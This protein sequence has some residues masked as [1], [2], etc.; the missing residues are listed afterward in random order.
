MGQG[1]LI[2]RNY[3]I[4]QYKEIIKY[5]N[6]HRKGKMDQRIRQQYEYFFFIS[7]TTNYRIKQ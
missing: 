4:E 3:R 1:V 5:P 2:T 7:V 6:S